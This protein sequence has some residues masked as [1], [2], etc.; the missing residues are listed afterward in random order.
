MMCEIF[1]LNT[2]KKDQKL[3]V[4][5]CTINNFTTIFQEKRSKSDAESTINAISV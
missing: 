2:D 5:F 4:T 1:R 3:M